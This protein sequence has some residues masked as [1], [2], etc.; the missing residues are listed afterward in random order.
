MMSA[1]LW[2]ETLK[3]PNMTKM[4]LFVH[5]SDLFPAGMTISKMIF[6]GEQENEKTV[7]SI[8]R[9]HLFHRM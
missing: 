6:T 8:R 1:K 4:V 9:S 7:D 2:V 5:L 3:S